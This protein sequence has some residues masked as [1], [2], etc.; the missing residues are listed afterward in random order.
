[1]EVR[2]D[3]FGTII[4]DDTATATASFA[5]VEQLLASLQPVSLDRSRSTASFTE[6][7]VQIT[8]HHVSGLDMLTVD[9]HYSAATGGMFYP[10]GFEEY[11]RLRDH[12]PVEDDALDDLRTVLRSAFDVE[13]TSWK[14]R[15]IRTLV[16]QVEPGERSSGLSVSGW[17]LPPR[18]ILPQRQLT[19]QHHRYSY[20]IQPP[21]EP[22]QGL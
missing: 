12:P 20:G 19:V 15:K 4:V 7:G 16:T 8:L 11:Y 22:A 18:W 6:T 13:E 21:T 5:K 3:W 10:L 17:L 1:M 2:S 14:G 9:L